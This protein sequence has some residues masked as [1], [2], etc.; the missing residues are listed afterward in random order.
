MQEVTLTTGPESIFQERRVV[1]HTEWAYLPIS[2]TRRIYQV[3]FKNM[4]ITP[5]HY[6][7]P[8]IIAGRAAFWYFDS[9]HMITHYIPTLTTDQFLKIERELDHAFEV[10]ERVQNSDHEQT[11]RFLHRLA[12]SRTKA[13]TFGSD[14]CIWGVGSPFWGWKWDR[15]GNPGSRAT[16]IWARLEELGF[17]GILNDAT[18][19]T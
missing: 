16:W 15:A 9:H 2:V 5:D 13:N 17:Y 8:V 6:I 18:G 3:I 1:T 10:N 7:H 12:Y 14:P 11:N 19:G 4:E